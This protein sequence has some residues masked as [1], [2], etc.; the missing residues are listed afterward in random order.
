[1][2]NALRISDLNVELEETKM[3]QAQER[4]GGAF[5][6]QG[7]AGDSLEWLCLSGRDVA[8]RFVLWLKSGEMD[9]GTVGSFQWRRVPDSARFDPR[10]GTMSEADK[11]KLPIPLHLGM[12]EPQ[13]LEALGRPTIRNGNTLLF[14]HEHDEGSKNGPLTVLNT[15]SIVLKDGAVWAIEVLKVSMS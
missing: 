4:F 8:G 5:G 15:V 14:V 11:I 9:D 6:N 3:D 1:M 2:V 10:C 12:S 7:D 13:I